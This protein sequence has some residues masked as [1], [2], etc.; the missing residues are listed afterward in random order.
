MNFL[1]QV[2][3]GQHPLIHYTVRYPQE[4]VMSTCSTGTYR[5][6]HWTSMNG[7]DFHS[8]ML[9]GQFVKHS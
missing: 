6:S 3:A 9:P 7:S 1:P 2:Q 5:M 8:Y 4:A